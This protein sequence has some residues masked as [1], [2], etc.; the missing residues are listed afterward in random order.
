MMNADVANMGAAQSFAL[1]WLLAEA[2]LY[3]RYRRE[4]GQDGQEM[5][6]R[7]AIEA[8][9]HTLQIDSDHKAAKTMIP[10]LGTALMDLYIKQ[11]RFDD[12][13]DLYN[14]LNI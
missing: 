3:L 8:F 1:G 12:F 7:K 9:R 6:L 5:M 14:E 2:E 4:D 13:Q 10:A 11:H